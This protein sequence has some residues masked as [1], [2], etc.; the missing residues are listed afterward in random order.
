MSAHDGAGDFMKKRPPG[1]NFRQ[2]DDERLCRCWLSVSPRPGN[3]LAAFVV[4]IRSMSSSVGDLRHSKAAEFPKRR[5]SS[6]ASPVKPWANILMAAVIFCKLERLITPQSITLLLEILLFG[7]DS[8]VN[9]QEEKL[10]HGIPSAE[11]ART[12]GWISR[13]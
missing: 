1:K 13:K 10:P 2:V 8:I 5:F 9:L 7:E 3:P 4:K 6:N 12:V 11:I